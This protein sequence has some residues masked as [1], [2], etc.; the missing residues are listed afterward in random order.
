MYNDALTNGALDIQ[1]PNEPGVMIYLLP[2]GN[3]VTIGNSSRGWG[4]PL[5]SFWCCY[6]TAIESFAKLGDSIYFHDPP[7]LQLWVAQFI[8]S[9]LRW[10]DAGLN[11]TQKAG[12]TP[13]SSALNF[14]IAVSTAAASGSFWRS[15]EGE[16]DNATKP[17]INIRIPKWA[18]ASRSSLTLNGASL[19][20][21]KPLV[22]GKVR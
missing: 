1:K 6:G 22:P 14:T 2:L 7:T 17:T 20:A 21:G 10:A 18:V 16:S 15:A 4:T 12:Y 19:T 8:S 11:L 3:G 13:D 5:N 9:D